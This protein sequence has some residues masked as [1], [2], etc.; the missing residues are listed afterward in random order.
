MSLVVISGNKQYIVEYGQNLIV[1][2]LNQKEGDIL[3][4]PVLFSFGTDKKQSQLKAFK[5]QSKI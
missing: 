4:L 5:I 2:K 3:E 1:D